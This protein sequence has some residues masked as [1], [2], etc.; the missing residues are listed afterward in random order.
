MQRFDR[1]CRF[2]V[3]VMPRDEVRTSFAKAFAKFGCN[4]NASRKK[5][6]VVLLQEGFVRGDAT[7]E[8]NPTPQGLC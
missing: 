8:P 7:A 5:Q 4:D 1:C 6:G 2:L 3:Q